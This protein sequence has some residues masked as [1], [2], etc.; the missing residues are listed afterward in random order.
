MQ[1]DKMKT[2]RVA[3]RSYASSEE[4]KDNA[5]DVMSIELTNQ[6]GSISMDK[7]AANMLNS[8][9]DQMEFEVIG[10]DEEN[11]ASTL[12]GNGDNETIAEDVITSGQTLSEND[13]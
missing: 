2:K 13:A 11:M 6:P 9:E 5:L 8:V 1:K 10:D 12:G 4:N 3:S 7:D